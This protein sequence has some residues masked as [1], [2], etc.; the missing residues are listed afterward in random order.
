MSQMQLPLLSLLPVYQL[1]P[2]MFP[3]PMHSSVSVQEKTGIS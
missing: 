1:L 2:T 3:P